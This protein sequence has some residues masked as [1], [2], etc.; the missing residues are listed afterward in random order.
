MSIQNILLGTSPN[1]V[2]FSSGESVVTTMYF[3]NT[4]SVPVNF[5]LYLLPAGKS[6]HPLNGEAVN[7]TS[8][9]IYYEVEIAPKDTYVID[10]E[11]LVFDVNDSIVAVASAPGVLLATVVGMGF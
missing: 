4:G 10:T 7:S 9:V 1:P 3:C 11:R 2:F 8:T 5:S 6:A